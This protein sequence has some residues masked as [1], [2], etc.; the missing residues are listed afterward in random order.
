MSSFQNIICPACTAQLCADE[1]SMRG[2]MLCAN[3]AV[4]FRL[5]QPWPVDR[6]SG[7]AIASFVLGIGSIGGLCFTGIPAFILGLWALNE[8][9]QRRNAETLTGRRLAIV[10]ATLGGLLSLVTFVV[11]LGIITPWGSYDAQQTEAM[12]MRDASGTKSVDR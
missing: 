9:Q 3:C 12:Q 5:G 4:Q 8:M 6:T 1:R 7:K 11:P 10:G 2:V